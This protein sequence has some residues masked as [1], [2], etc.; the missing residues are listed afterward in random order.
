MVT[1]FQNFKIVNKFRS[2][3]KSD[4]RFHKL[5]SS[6]NCPQVIMVFFFKE[7]ETFSVLTRK[8][9]M[10]GCGSIEQIFNR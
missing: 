10:E 8:K 7:D 1:G 5:S 4:I 2:L 3:K 6:T 9:G